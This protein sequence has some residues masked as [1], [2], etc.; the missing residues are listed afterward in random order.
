MYAHLAILTEYF[1]NYL[2]KPLHPRKP[3]AYT[4]GNLVAGNLAQ[5]GGSVG[6]WCVEDTEQ[7]LPDLTRL[8]AGINSLPDS[9]LL[10]VTNNW[11][12]LVVVSHETLLESVCVVIRSLDKWLASNIVLHGLLGWVEDLVV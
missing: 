10:V 4:F 2:C 12:C 9:S 3:V 6:F 1:W 8:L 5:Q 7:A 11:C